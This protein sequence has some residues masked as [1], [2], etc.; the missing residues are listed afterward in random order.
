[1]TYWR[2]A[3]LF[4]QG[5][6]IKNIKI[7]GN[8]LSNTR[9]DSSVLLLWLIIF[10]ALVCREWRRWRAA[11]QHPVSPKIIIITVTIMMSL[12]FNL[13]SCVNKCFPSLDSSSTLFFLFF[14]YITFILLWEFL[15]SSSSSCLS[16]CPGFFGVFVI[17]P[18]CCQRSQ[19]MCRLF[20]FYRQR[21]AERRHH[22]WRRW[23][24]SSGRDTIV[25][26]C[27]CFFDYIFVLFKLYVTFIFQGTL[28]FRF[29]I[30]SSTRKEQKKKK[31]HGSLLN[32]LT[33]ADMSSTLHKQ[34][35]KIE[36]FWWS[37]HPSHIVPICS[38][39]HSRYKNI[40]QMSFD[41]TGRE[42]EQAFRLNKDPLAELEYPTKWEH[43]KK[44]TPASSH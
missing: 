7:S 32:M 13:F 17:L 14:P 39:F 28:P 29:R 36:I 4:T 16:P 37:F 9:V 25:S 10:F 18:C 21:E 3:C 43:E 30:E 41:D 35:H 11:V 2:T 1:M 6:N 34:N 26:V 24:V 22:F 8:I 12:S 31:A 33:S 5:K 40:P 44:M 19:R 42:P 20:Q 27:H 15:T 38:F 23:R